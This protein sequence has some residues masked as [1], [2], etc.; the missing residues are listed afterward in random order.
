[1]KNLLHFILAMLIVV[2]ILN[3]CGGKPRE[4]TQADKCEDAKNDKRYIDEQQRSAG[5]NLVR[6]AELYNR[7]TDALNRI[8]KYCYDNPNG[9]DGK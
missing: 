7:E 1:M 2:P 8:Q 5:Q 6:Q 3:N 9:Y 4:K